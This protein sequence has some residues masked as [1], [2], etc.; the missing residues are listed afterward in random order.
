MKRS[1][2]VDLLTI[3]AL[4]LGT[5]QTALVTLPV[6]PE[7]LILWSAII[8]FGTTAITYWK[9]NLSVEVSNASK[10][11]TIILGSIAMLGLVNEYLIPVIKV[12]ETAG[13]WIR[14]GI[15]A[16]TS[17]LNLAS[18]ILFKTDQTTSKI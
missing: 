11:P 14:F 4:F 15:T 3:F 16:A 12:S 1:T 5:V 9:Q 13:M 7:K 2:V 8:T 17:L 10:I 6:N 18:K